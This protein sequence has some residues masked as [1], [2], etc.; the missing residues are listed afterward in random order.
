M[1]TFT[2]SEISQLRG[3]YTM[4]IHQMFPEVVFPRCSIVALDAGKRISHSTHVL[5]VVIE[6]VF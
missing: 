6:G 2:S 3:L 1:H 4:N 5:L